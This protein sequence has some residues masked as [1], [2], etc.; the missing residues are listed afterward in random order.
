[1]AYSV[2]RT[3]YDFA[4]LKEKYTVL[5]LAA[6]R[7]RGENLAGSIRE[8][9]IACEYIHDKGEFKEGKVTV[10]KGELKKGFE[11]PALK[12]VVISDKEI[13]NS[14]I[15]RRRRK[16]ENTNRIRTTADRVQLK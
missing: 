9:G 12:L 13:F 10:L 3:A 11:Y 4:I 16:E 7:S 2:L 8:K 14:K 6:N 5:I 1:M 15:S